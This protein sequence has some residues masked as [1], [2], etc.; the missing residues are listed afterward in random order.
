MDRYSIWNEP[1]WKTWLGPLKAAPAIYRSM[2][3][4]AYD[5]IKAADPR[6]KVL[7]GETSPYERRGLSTAPLALLR[8]V[9][10]VN[11]NYRRVGNCPRLRADGYAHHPYDFT[12]PPNYQYPGADNV[13]IGTLPRLTRALDRLARS[14][15]LRFNGGGRMPLYLTEYGYFATGTAG[16]ARAH[17]LALPA[18]GVLD[19]AAQRAREE[20]APVPAHHA[21]AQLGVLVQHGARHARR[22]S[23]CRSTTR[24]SAGIARTAVGSSGR[25]RRSRC[26]SRPR[27]PPS[28]AGAVP[29]DARERLRRARLYLVVEAAAE[30]VLAA[31]LRGGVDMVQLRD[32]HA[33][34]DDDPARGRALPRA[35]AAST[36]RCSGSTTAPTSR[37]SAGADGVHVGQDDTPVAE[38]RAQVGPD[39]LIGLSTHSPEQFDA[40][41]GSEADQLSV[42]PVWET[43]TKEGRPAAGLDYVRHAAGPAASGPGSRSA[44]STPA[45]VAQVVAAG[46]RRIVVLRAIRDAADPQAAAA[47]LARVCRP[48]GDDPDRPAWMVMNHRQVRR[49]AY[50]EYRVTVD[51]V[52][53]LTEVKPYWL[54]VVPCVSDPQY[55]VPGGRAPGSTHRRSKTIAMPA[56]GRIVAVGGHLHGG[57]HSL[58]LSQPG[59]GNRTIACNDATY[60]GAADQLYGVRP[61]LHEPDPKNMTWSQ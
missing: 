8:K 7:I 4:R 20:P 32:K 17:A 1:N 57:S 10:C 14:G 45:N 19:R 29:A 43:P 53:G 46:A 47:A 16:A 41:L 5:A 26:R 13:T 56:A 36:V 21:A 33:G 50:V 51:S 40:A 6:A 2:Y 55:K 34:D 37:S 35:S 42:G 44:G 27:T 49:Q 15:A 58:V 60:A 48:A 12:H 22:A 23:A 9:T 3:V 31:A 59:C 25:A 18:A 52:P 30:P 61:L 28:E 11:R 38:V 24:C 54:S 39:L